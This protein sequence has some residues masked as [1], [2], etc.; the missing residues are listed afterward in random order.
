[1]TND[2]TG[3]R[4]MHMP[5]CFSCAHYKGGKGKMT[6]YAYPVEIP[7]RIVFGKSDAHDQVQD[8]QQGTDVFMIIPD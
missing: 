3:F 1:M 5:I 6:C 8:D 2:L 7:D 4:V